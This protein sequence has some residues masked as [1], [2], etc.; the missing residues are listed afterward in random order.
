MQDAID[1]GE[2]C[3]PETCAADSR[4]AL[5]AWQEFTRGMQWCCSAGEWDLP[6]QFDLARWVY[7]QPSLLVRTS[8]WITHAEPTQTCV[9]KHVTPPDLA[10]I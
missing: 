3:I 6:H 10:E 4:T 2:E 7:I 9:Q 5:A 1:L 8:F